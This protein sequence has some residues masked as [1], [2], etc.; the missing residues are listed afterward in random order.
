MDHG[1]CRMVSALSRHAALSGSYRHIL[2]AENGRGVPGG[3]LSARRPGPD[4]SGCRQHDGIAGFHVLSSARPRLSSAHFHQ[5]NAGYRIPICNVKKTRTNLPV[6]LKIDTTPVVQ[7]GI[8]VKMRDMPSAE[9][10]VCRTCDLQF[11][12][13]QGIA[14]TS[15]RFLRNLPETTPGFFCDKISSGASPAGCGPTENVQTT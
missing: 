6:L 14:V 2:G 13:H 12:R 10:P 11:L 7:T 4:S 1:L 9:H 5:F 3:F 15:I 8:D